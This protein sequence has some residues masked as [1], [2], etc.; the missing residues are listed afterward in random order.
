M[1]KAPQNSFL[2]REK[3]LSE[4]TLQKLK[5]LFAPQITT[6]WILHKDTRWI[7]SKWLYNQ[8]N[9]TNEQMDAMDR[10][11]EKIWLKIAR[12][13]RRINWVVCYRRVDAHDDTEIQ[14]DN[15]KIR[16]DDCS[17]VFVPL[18]GHKGWEFILGEPWKKVSTPI[19][20]G[21]VIVLDHNVEHEVR[22][23]TNNDRLKFW[24]SF[25]VDRIIQSPPSASI[26]QQDPQSPSTQGY[27][28][29]EP[30]DHSRA[31]S[32]AEA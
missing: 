13:Y 2:A 1:L 3:P 29:L 17:F 19:Q 28:P 21:S 24:L 18:F 7:H 14:I 31:L 15:E 12:R 9:F 30:L 20:D 5:L 26:H 22:F 25:L 27:P 16:V 4:H 10:V 32:D 23:P 6:M 8:P 11:L